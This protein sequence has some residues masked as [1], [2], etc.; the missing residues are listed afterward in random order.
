MPSGATMCFIVASRQ[1]AS[2]PT[3]KKPLRADALSGFVVPAIDSFGK[4]RP[5]AQGKD[6]AAWQQNRRVDLVYE[7]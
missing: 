4:E 6:E 1:T 3:M 7:P 2:P 5:R